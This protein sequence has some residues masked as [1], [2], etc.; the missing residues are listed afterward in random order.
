MHEP[1]RRPLKILMERSGEEGRMR[2][3]P[4]PAAGAGL[5]GLCECPGTVGGAGEP[6]VDQTAEVE[7]G[8][9]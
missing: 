6:E 1:A 4:D 3:V 9:V 8:P 5:E 7:G 2:G